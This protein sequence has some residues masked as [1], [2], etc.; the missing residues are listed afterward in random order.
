MEKTLLEQVQEHI[1]QN[2][3][4][5][6]PFYLMDE[7]IETTIFNASIFKE[8]PDFTRIRLMKVIT[9]SRCALLTAKID[10][11]L[12]ISEYAT[13]EAKEIIDWCLAYDQL[14]PVFD[15]FSKIGVFD[16]LN[17]IL[18]KEIELAVKQH[19]QLGMMEAK[20]AEV[21]DDAIKLLNTID[22]TIKDEKKL[23]KLITNIEKKAPNL[24]LIIKQLGE[25]VPNVI[26][27]INNILPN[28]VNQE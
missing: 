21:A 4:L 5:N 9:F 8:K 22:S 25:Y 6:L 1:K 15:E 12:P 3:K 10:Y 19:L 13:D 14:E 20:F 26:G 18:E 17:E 11:E 2:G 16:T 28:K 27:K 24:T 23:I 7:A